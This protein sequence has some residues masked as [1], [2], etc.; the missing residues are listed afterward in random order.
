METVELQ[1]EAR[2]GT[3]K[4][5]CRKLRAKGRLPGVVY[6]RALAAQAISCDK[7]GLV[8]ALGGSMGRNTCFRLSGPKDLDGRVVVPASCNGPP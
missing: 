8:A 1:V 6:G 3:G 7:E 4:G 2:S 5:A